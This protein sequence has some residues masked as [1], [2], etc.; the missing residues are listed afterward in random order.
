MKFLEAPDVL[1]DVEYGVEE[2]ICEDNDG[3]E[4]KKVEFK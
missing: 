1:V 4:K 2:D 3:N